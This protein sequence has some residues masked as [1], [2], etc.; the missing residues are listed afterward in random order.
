[1]RKILL[2]LIIALFGYSFAA[3][4]PLENVQGMVS[5]SVNY[6][7]Y[8]DNQANAIR[9][10]ESQ[11]D[12]MAHREATAAER[13]VIASLMESLIPNWADLVRL[14]SDF[15]VMV[16]RSPNLG[17]STLSLYVRGVLTRF[18]QY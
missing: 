8:F 16:V 14:H 18:W 2:V 6:T 10:L 7:V 15:A 13:R 17:E 9:W 11:T 3:A 4:N 5:F 12:F 1:M